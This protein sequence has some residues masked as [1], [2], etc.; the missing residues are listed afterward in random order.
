MA[1]LN[2]TIENCQP[3][4]QGEEIRRNY[5]WQTEQAQIAVGSGG[6]FGKGLTQGIQ[7]SYWLPQATDDFIFAAS[8]EELGFLRIAFILAAYIVIGYRGFMIANFAPD[9]F[10]ALTVTG[11]TVW[12]IMQAFINIGVNI[13]LLPVTGITLPFVSYGGT[14]MIA[15][16]AGVGVLLQISKTTTPYYANSIQRRGD[17]GSHIFQHPPFYSTL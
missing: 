7:K 9:R 10:T 3:E 6:F 13:G 1:Y 17:R 12:L 2:P 11:I 4:P 5:C 8:A 16:L 14:S 15:T